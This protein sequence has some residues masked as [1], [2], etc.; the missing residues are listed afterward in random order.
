MEVAFCPEVTQA[1]VLKWYPDATKAES[2]VPVVQPPSTPM[3]AGEEVAVRKW[4]ELIQEIDP[5]TIAQVLEQ[6]RKDQEAKLYFLKRAGE[7]HG[8]R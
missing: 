2:F 4:L 8:D 5:A 6:C 1:E 7:I 3:T